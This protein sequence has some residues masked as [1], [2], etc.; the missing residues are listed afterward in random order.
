MLHASL[1]SSSLII[2][3]SIWWSVPITKLL[4]MQSPPPSCYFL[5][6]RSRCYPQHFVFIELSVV[7]LC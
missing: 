1:I 5:S 2:S 7:W 3:V 4:I 6:L